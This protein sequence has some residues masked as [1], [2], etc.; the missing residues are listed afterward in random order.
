MRKT[1]AILMAAALALG[2][3]TTTGGGAGAT[4]GASKICA[5]VP[6]STTRP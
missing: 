3:C 1:L 5:G 2:A 6:C 4:G